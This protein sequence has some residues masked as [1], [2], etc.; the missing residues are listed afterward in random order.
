MI[1]K[2]IKIAS[3]IF[4]IHPLGENALVLMAEKISLIDIH[5][6]ASSIE[7]K[8]KNKIIDIVTAYQ[9]IT[10]YFDPLV[11]SWDYLLNAFETIFV[12]NIQKTSIKTH[13]IIVDFEK[14]L[15]WESVEMTTNL[16]KSQIISLF[17]AKKYTVAMLGFIPGF[18]YLEGLDRR[19]TCPRKN[20][21]R[22]KVPKGSI[23]IGGEQAGIYS[24]SSPG[25]WRIIGQT[26]T[27]I[28]QSHQT[29]PI[30]ILPLHH[31]I[32]KAKFM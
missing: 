3:N 5:Q 4:K 12:S 31:V 16:S 29:T 15:D 9:S 27:A 22:A 17:L 20:S 7:K 13:E 8:L 23:G 19:L 21:P 2:E 32:F 26:T 11:I 24:L 18:I 30:S 14:G 25:G 10:I 28:F 6:V 1:E